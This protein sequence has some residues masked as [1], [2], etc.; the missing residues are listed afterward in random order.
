MDQ[1]AGRQE[2]RA[3]KTGEGLLNLD[4]VPE[5][6]VE[7]LRKSSKSFKEA[8]T[9]VDGWHPRQYGH[10]SDKALRAL[11]FLFRLYEATPYWCQVQSSLLV[12]LILK[13]DGDLRPNFW[14]R[15]G[16]WIWW[17]IYFL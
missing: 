2:P 1:G 8:T 14:F 3:G 12:R 13:L 16:T 6:T 15:S 4:R 17:T 10:L 7:Q 5:L 9:K 11:G